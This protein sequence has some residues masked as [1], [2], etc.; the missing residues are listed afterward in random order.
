MVLSPGSY[1]KNGNGNE[2]WRALLAPW[3]YA[4]THLANRSTAPKSSSSDGNVAAEEFYLLADDS[5]FV[6]VDNLR[7]F[8]SSLSLDSSSQPLYI[9]RRFRLPFAIS[10]ALLRGK[11]IPTLHLVRCRVRTGCR[12]VR[13][14]ECS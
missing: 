2:G 10:E 14:C 8:L 6:L 5:L 4:Y 12:G 13:T 9:G 11:A 7:R 1:P 3:A